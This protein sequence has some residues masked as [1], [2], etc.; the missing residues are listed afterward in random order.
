[1]KSVAACSMAALVLA[2][3]GCNRERS[4][5]R[6]HSGFISEN[7]RRNPNEQDKSGVTTLTGASWLANDAAIDRIVASRCA[8]EVTCSNVGPDK[9]F[10]SGEICVRE[11][12]SKMSDQLRASECP[13]GIDSKE[14]EECLDAIRSESCTNPLDTVSRLAA[15]RTSDLCLKTE[16]PH[17]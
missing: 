13:S 7:D 4:S 6:D 8:R 15:C 11:V 1:M 5:N 16:M 14:L 17:R 3:V 2:L 9:H 10:T 12:R